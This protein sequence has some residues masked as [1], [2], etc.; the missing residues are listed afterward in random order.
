MQVER[1]WRLMK[2][3]PDRTNRRSTDEIWNSLREEK[4]FEDISKRTVERDLASLQS[5]FPIQQSTEGRTNYWYWA[6]GVSMW[7]PGLTDDEALAF[8]MVERNMRQLLPEGSI[9]RLG[10]YFKVANAKLAA[11]AGKIRPQ[12]QKFRLIASGVPRVAKKIRNAEASGRVRN[13]LLKDQQLCI[14]YWGKGE[15]GIIRRDDGTIAD[16]VPLDAIINPLAIIQRDSELFLVFTK[17]GTREPQF[18]ALREIESATPS[19][20]R[21]DGPEDFDVDA[22]IKS[23]ALHFE[24]DLPIRIGDWIQLSAS[25]TKEAR[26][27]LYNTPLVASEQISRDCDGRTRFLMPVR[28]TADLADWLL[29][30]GPKVRVHQ[31]AAL[32]RWLAA[33]LA[34]AADQYRGEDISE[35]PQHSF[36]WYEKWGAVELTCAHCSWN[37]RASPKELEPH[38]AGKQQTDCEFRC[39]QCNKLLMVVDYIATVDDLVK[40]WDIIDPGIRSA[41][42]STPERIEQ[43]EQKKLKS[44]DQL[45]DLKSS[46]GFLT[47]NIVSHESGEISNVV[48]HGSHM[49]WIQPAL[50]DGASEFVRVAEILGKKY[51]GRIR[52]IRISPEARAYLSPDKVAEHKKI[53]GARLK[54]KQANP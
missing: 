54:F 14:S 29:S 45:P 27:R 22:Y 4:D 31:P 53:E 46:V 47:W 10:S 36:R 49:I 44:P 30:L 13:A 52:D 39:P 28:F 33:K 34:A 11:H 25:F 40:N 20:A 26:D 42:L 24:Q 8:H 17:R 43:F 19:L 35:E 2:L 41:V 23:G 51:A 6:D 15:E 48:R 18:I 21:F 12:T 9:E 32:R 37:G 50:W 7:L 1:Q 38:D 5:F 16:L 3:I